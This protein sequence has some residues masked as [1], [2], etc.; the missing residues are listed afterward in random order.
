ML[1]DEVEAVADFYQ[2]ELMQRDTSLLRGKVAMAGF[3]HD[4]QTAISPDGI[5]EVEVFQVAVPAEELVEGTVAQ[6]GRA[7]DYRR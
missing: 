4:G 1:T 7:P 5:A 6:N 3:G 2:P